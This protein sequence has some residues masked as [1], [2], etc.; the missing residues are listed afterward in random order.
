MGEICKVLTVLFYFYSHCGYIT[1]VTPFVH[2]YDTKPDVW[3]N[4]VSLERYRITLQEKNSKRKLV[5][6]NTYL[7][8]S[9]WYILSPYIDGRL[10]KEL[11]VRR[12][13]VN[14]GSKDVCWQMP[15]VDVVISDLTVYLWRGDATPLPL[16]G[17]EGIKSIVISAEKL[18]RHLARKWTRS[19]K[20]G[21]S[22][23]LSWTFQASLFQLIISHY[24]LVE[25]FD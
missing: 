8:Y 16:R 13:T 17:S 10:F 18:Y 21:G 20:Y 5:F 19:V 9:V 11:N 1:T 25:E 15:A 24:V 4:D 12:W 6:G 3:M 23:H 7:I 2:L 14:S 22:G